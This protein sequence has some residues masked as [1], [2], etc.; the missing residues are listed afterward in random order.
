LAQPPHERGRDRRARGSAQG[1]L[2]ERARRPR[3]SR[4]DP[5]DGPRA[6]EAEARLPSHPG[7]GRTPLGAE[8]P[9]IADEADP[10]RGGCL[11]PGRESA[12]AGTEPLERG[13]GRPTR[14]HARPLL[15]GLGQVLLSGVPQEAEAVKRRL[16]G[17]PAALAEGWSA[18]VAD[19]MAMA[20][21]EY[22]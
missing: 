14:H 20:A 21:T 9:A 3:P 19:E 6:V 1:A 10:R 7:L 13:P 5:R 8:A 17:L 4:A 16:E 18:A 11:T 2:A 22:V 12:R 15:V